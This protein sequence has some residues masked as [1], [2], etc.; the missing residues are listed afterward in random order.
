MVEAMVK[1]LILTII[2][3]IVIFTVVAEVGPDVQTAGNAINATTLPLA[4]LFAGDG[5]MPLIMM[6]GV[7]LIGIGMFL[8]K[9]G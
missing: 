1:G 6:A 4:G 5:V 8:K 2:G 7:V 3:A 9:R